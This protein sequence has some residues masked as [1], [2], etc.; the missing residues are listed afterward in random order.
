MVRLFKKY[1]GEYDF[2]YLMISAQAYQESGLD[3]NKRSP[4]GAIGV[5]Q[6]LPT[7]AKDPNVNIPDIQK[8][9]NNIHAGT[10]YL[11]FIIDRYYEDEPMNDLNKLLFGFAA[12]NAGPSKINALRRKAGAMGLDPNVWFYYVEIVAAKSIGRETVQYVSNIYK[13][14]I[15]Y[16]M[17]HLQA[18]KKQAGMVN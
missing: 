16:Q 13:Y 4:S 3:Q 10:K 7:T 6:V 18:E 9:E 2:N 1:A 5:M 17:V 14:Y 15:S 11:R 8:L 12:Y